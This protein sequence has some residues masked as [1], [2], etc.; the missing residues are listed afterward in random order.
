VAVDLTA[1]LSEI[2]LVSALPGA[3]V[4]GEPE[5]A[6]F[7]LLLPVLLWPEPVGALSPTAPSAIVPA[8]RLLGPLA[9]SLPKGIHP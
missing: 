2:R 3:P 4:P 7:A 5:D 8:G 6:A 9:V 1:G